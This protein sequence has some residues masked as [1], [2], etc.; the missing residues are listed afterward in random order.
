[1]VRAI[2]GAEGPL[3]TRRKKKKASAAPLINVL[4]TLLALI[5]A[6]TLVLSIKERSIEA[7][8]RMA[9]GWIA[10]GWAGAQKL[11]GRTPEAEP[12]AATA[13]DQLKP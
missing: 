4:V 3:W 2:D 9:D 13:R 11:A 7:A 5:G 1:M 12:G 6:L 10:T 8:G